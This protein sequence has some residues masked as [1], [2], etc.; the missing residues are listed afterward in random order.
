M[1]RHSRLSRS[2][3]NHP[4]AELPRPKTNDSEPRP[5]HR[6]SLSYGTFSR[7]N[8]SSC[9]IPSNASLVRVSLSSSLRRTYVLSFSNY[10]RFFLQCRF[11]YFFLII[12]LF[13]YRLCDICTPSYFLFI[14]ICVQMLYASV[15]SMYLY[16]SC[17]CIYM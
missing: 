10:R 2:L 13:I 8:A 15:F 3:P 5:P 16:S 7:T 14:Y 12:C 11:L 17:V 4:R 6:R 9:V 1:Y